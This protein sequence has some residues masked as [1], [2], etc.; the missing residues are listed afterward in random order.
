MVLRFGYV[1]YF[2]AGPLQ[3]FDPVVQSVLPCIDYAADAGLD[4]HRFG[5]ATLR[6]RC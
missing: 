6:K 1:F 4:D 5:T 3:E 2:Y